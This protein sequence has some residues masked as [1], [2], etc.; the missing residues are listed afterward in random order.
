[1]RFFTYDGGHSYVI[2]SKDSS[3][4]LTAKEVSELFQLMINE[5]EKAGS[6]LPKP[7]LMDDHEDYW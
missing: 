7:S 3:L 5:A 6:G 2:E 1:M 4:H